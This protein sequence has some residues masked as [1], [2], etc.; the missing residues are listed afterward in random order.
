MQRWEESGCYAIYRMLWPGVETRKI[1]SNAE[2][3]KLSVC[4]RR[5]RTCISDEAKHTSVW[6]NRYPCNSKTGVFGNAFV[7]SQDE[8]HGSILVRC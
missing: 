4:A 7:G 1:S 8:S 3:Y 5:A 2:A 6:E